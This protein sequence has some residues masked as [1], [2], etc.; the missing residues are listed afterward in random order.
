MERAH[1]VE[2]VGELHQQHADIVA[3]SEQELAKVLRGALILRLRLDLAEL[4]NSVDQAGDVLAEQ[5]LD[6]FRSRDRILDRVVKDGGRDRLVVE[7]QVG[8]DSRDFD[9]VTEIRIPRR[10]NLRPVSLHREDVGTVDQPFVRIRI[11]G[12]DFLDQLILSQ[13][14]PKMGLGCSIVQARKVYH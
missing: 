5:P 9:R 1:V 12:A 3:E 11:V 13:H 7:L 4:G 2:P 6:L 10:A 14:A 8:E